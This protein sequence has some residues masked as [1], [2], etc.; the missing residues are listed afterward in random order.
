MNN[1]WN[2]LPKPFTALAPM[3]GVTDIVF[4]QMMI[5]IGR[6]DVFFTEFTSTSG[7]MSKGFDKVSK[8]L[9]FKK[10]EL[11]IV[12][13]IWGLNPKDFYDTAKLCKK[14]G[15]SG[16]DLNMGCP[17]YTVIR[18]GACSA[19]INN[20]KLAKEIISATKEGAGGLPV[21]VKTRVGFDKE[22]IDDWIAFLLEQDLPALII[23]LR[24]VAELS[25][26]DAHWELMPKI[27]KLKNEIALNTLIV[28][29]G[30]IKTKQEISEK[31]N[32]SGLD[33]FM[34]GR[35][36]FYDP[37][38]FNKSFDY[39]METAVMRLNLYLE[40]IKLFEKIWKDGKNPESLKKFS[41]MYI[42]NFNGA[43]EFRNEINLTKTAPEMINLINSHLKKIS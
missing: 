38:I 34:I 25:K 7:L 23:H 27:I 12:A 17:I 41:K 22:Q 14:M 2:D 32:K 13:Q 20:R 11:P 19:L 21:S 39:K 3:E 16:I 8:S 30:D 36:V 26:V 9:K 31:Y 6:P 37:W 33:G 5:R 35:G 15:F 28:G 18:K 4:R 10:N 43:T 29:N 24:T 42:N 40:H 1:F